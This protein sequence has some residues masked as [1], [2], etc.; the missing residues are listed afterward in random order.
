MTNDTGAARGA[1]DGAATATALY[2]AFGRGDITTVLA[3]LDDGIE[4]RQAEG[5]PYRLDGT[6]WVGP[7]V[8]L[9]E[10]FARLAQDFDGLTVQPHTITSTDEGAVVQGRYTGM[11]KATGR[12]LDSQFCHV[13]R[14]RDG[15]VTHFQQYLDT[16]TLQWA[17]GHTPVR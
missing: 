3:M 6:P 12:R 16:S 7:Q 14:M 13:L 15:R 8:V 9:T 5:H 1:S 17:M 4:W 11:V 2:E 10:L